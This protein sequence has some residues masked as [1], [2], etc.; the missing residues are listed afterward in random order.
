MVSYG[1][2]KTIEIKNHYRFNQ[3]PPSV[4]I[5]HDTS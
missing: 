2:F 5:S 3:L 4:V 1:E